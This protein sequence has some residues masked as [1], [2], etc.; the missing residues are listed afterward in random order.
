MPNMT[1]KMQHFAAQIA[2]GVK[3]RE[4][5]ISAGYAP[6]TAAQTA[7][8]L[9]ARADIKAE[10]K[11]VRSQK[12]VANPKLARGGST[13]IGDEKP[14]MKD[15]YASSLELL[16]DLYNNKKAPYAL[17]F[18][19]AKQGEQG[20]KEKAKDVAKEKAGAGKFKKKAP[21][22]ISHAAHMVN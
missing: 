18:E 5:A 17:R 12:G 7:S 6:A 4:A 22:R 8:K 3:G 9:L 13:D 15:H 11:R 21:P 2:L 19:A 16:R 10:V 1:E 14:L 20:K